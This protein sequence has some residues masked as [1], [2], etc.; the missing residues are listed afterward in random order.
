MAVANIVPTV[1]KQVDVIALL[2]LEPVDPPF[3]KEI[4]RWQPNLV[5]S[6]KEDLDKWRRFFKSLTASKSSELESRVIAT[7]LRQHVDEWLRTG[8]TKDGRECLAN[9]SLIKAPVAMKVLQ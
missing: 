7:R 1:V 6:N 8:W 5:S 3:L 2:N 4:E 9:R